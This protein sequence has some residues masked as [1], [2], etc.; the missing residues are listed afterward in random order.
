MATKDDG[1][2]KERE[3]WKKKVIKDKSKTLLYNV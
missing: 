2:K 1:K 3:R